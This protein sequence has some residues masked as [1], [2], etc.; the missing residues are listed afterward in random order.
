MDANTGLARSSLLE[1]VFT[2]PDSR[3]AMRVGMGCDVSPRSLVGFAA[4]HT[5][6]SRGRSA[7]SFWLQF[8]P[9][10]FLDTRHNPSSIHAGR[11]RVAST[12]L[13][14][15]LLPRARRRAPETG[16]RGRAEEFVLP[17]CSFSYLDFGSRVACRRS[18]CYE[19]SAIREHCGFTNVLLFE[20]RMAS[21]LLCFSSDDGAFFFSPYD[22]RRRNGI[23]T[24]VHYRRHSGVCTTARQ[25][26][27]NHRLGNVR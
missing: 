23:F 18:T 14:T 10:V 25:K 20:R 13:A 6:S 7:Q 17:P 26:R 1:Q 3:H 27:L 5:S 4:N 2:V 9:H 19:S 15:E 11:A 22:P 16:N 12:T 8:D 21:P 24:V